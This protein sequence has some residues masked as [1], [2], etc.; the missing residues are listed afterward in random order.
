MKI[1]SERKYTPLLSDNDDDIWKSIGIAGSVL[2]ERRRLG[3]RRLAGQLNKT[4]NK[5]IIYG[6]VVVEVKFRPKNLNV[7]KQHFYAF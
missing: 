3:V 1:H 2:V 7:C 6:V 4:E 5:N